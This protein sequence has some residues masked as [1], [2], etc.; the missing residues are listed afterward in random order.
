MQ[1]CE[2]R[3]NEPNAG[4]KP[5]TRKTLADG[6]ADSLRNAIVQGIFRPGQRLTEMHLADH[7]QVS[8]APVREALACLEQEGLVSRTP[9]GG[10]LVARLSPADIEE[11]CTLRMAL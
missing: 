11:V 10:A 1:A 4:L 2:A 5:P 8:R 6:A 7:L 9:G 3:M